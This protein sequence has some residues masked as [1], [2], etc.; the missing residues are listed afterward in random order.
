MSRLSRIL[1]EVNA[2]DPIKM[3]LSDIFTL[4]VNLAGLPG[5][6]VPCGLDSQMLPIGLQLIG[7]RFDEQTLFNIASS[8]ER[9]RGDFA[10]PAWKGDN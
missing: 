5:I 8:Y 4:P 9:V 1:F 3:Y 6:S 2:R 10:L 7:R